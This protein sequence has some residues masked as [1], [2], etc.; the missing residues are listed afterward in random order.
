M[1]VTEH[2]KHLA[3]LIISLN[4]L[5]L[6]LKDI[7]FGFYQ[8]NLPPN[9]VISLVTRLNNSAQHNYI[10]CFPRPRNEA[11]SLLNVSLQ[12]KI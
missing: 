1:D 12:Y 11:A 6:N 3:S 10:A 9:E 8:L 4:Y 7:H 5:L 2:D